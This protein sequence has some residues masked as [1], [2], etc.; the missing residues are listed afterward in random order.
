MSYGS[1]AATTE[2]RSAHPSC[3]GGRSCLRGAWRSGLTYLDVLFGTAV[4]V[5]IVVTLS[6]A[7]THGLRLSRVARARTQVL[8]AAQAEVERLRTVT[9][10]QVGSY[11]VSGE[12]L[13]GEVQVDLV[14]PRQKRVVVRLRHLEVPAATVVLMIDVYPH[15][16][17]R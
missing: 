12:L 15:A 2:E 13:A 10:E 7:L 6:M 1:L 8:G 11:P 17:A 16:P 14:S 4:T 9:F 3:S 5:L